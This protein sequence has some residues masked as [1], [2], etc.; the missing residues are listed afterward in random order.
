MLLTATDADI[1]R[2]MSKVDI[3]PNDCWYWT[4]ARSRGKGNK[5]WY[6]SFGI[7]GKVVRA[8]RFSS[9]VFNCEECPPGFHRDHTCGFSMCVNPQH[10]EVLTR[11]E[12]QRRKMAGN[13]TLLQNAYPTISYSSSVVF[14]INLGISGSYPIPLAMNSKEPFSR[15]DESWQNYLKQTDFGQKSQKQ[16]TVGFGIP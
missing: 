9:E 1:E 10:I 11:E 14:D 16:I 6:G 7:G 8:H 3:L 15:K 12:N 2:F 4:G 13:K 5:K